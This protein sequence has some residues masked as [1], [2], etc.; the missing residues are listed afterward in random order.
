MF[1]DYYS[2]LGISFPS[3]NEEIKH[4]YC[5]KVEALGS[6]SSKCS[7]PDYQKRV[8][9]EVAY[10]VLGVSYS[11]KTAYDEEYQQYTETPDKEC[12]EIKDDWTKSQIKSEIDFVVNRILVPESACQG[13]TEK[14]GIGNKAIGCVGKILGFIFLIIMIAGVKTCARK[15]VRN[16]F[17]NSYV[18][19]ETEDKSA[20]SSNNNSEIKLQKTA[21]EINQTLPRQLDSNITHQAISLTPSALVYEYIVD[22]IFFSKVKDQVLSIDNQ[23]ANIRMM[24]SDMKPMIDLLIETNRGISYKYVCKKSKSTNIVTVSCDDLRALFSKRS[25]S[26]TYIYNDLYCIEIPNILEIKQS[27]LNNLEH[28]QN[29]TVYVTT[30]SGNIIFQQKGLND[31]EETSLNK[32]CRVIIEYFP[33]DRNEP[34]YG[35]GDQIVVDKDVL[36]EIN[37]TVE[38]NCEASGTPLI[39]LISVQPLSIND[40]P[41]L[42][43]SYKR[44]GWEGKQPP[45]IVNVFRIFNLYESVTLTFSYRESEREEWKSIHDYIINTFS[46]SDRY[47]EQNEGNMLEL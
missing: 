24:Y 6:E 14:N 36:Y 11:L 37:N 38:K 28:P 5:K 12:L 30:S 29:N 2:I 8:D 4:A 18:E 16:S 46:F 31:V 45:V 35:C 1:K 10:R 27:E 22:D 7:S 33:E 9:V 23:L 47:F 25:K 40:Y 26:T 15:Q 41:V 43:Y 13:G 39:K 19:P 32:Y 34:T 20:I 17:E 42:Y 21:R 3:N 44:K